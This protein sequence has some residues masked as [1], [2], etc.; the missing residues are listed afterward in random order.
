MEQL[1]Q[2]NFFDDEDVVQESVKASGEFFDDADVVD[3]PAP[4][5]AP[6]KPKP[7]IFGKIYQA[8]AD[9]FSMEKN[10]NQILGDMMKNVV[11]DVA[12][13][14]EARDFDPRPMAAG[15]TR[16]LSAGFSD[17]IAGKIAVE[18]D[19]RTPD[20]I[21]QL[22]SGV[23][24]NTD[25]SFDES[26]VD[27]IY[28]SARDTERN[29]VAQ[30]EKENPSSVMAGDLAASLMLPYGRVV[31]GAQKLTGAASTLKALEAAR[32]AKVAKAA[33]SLP[34]AKAAIEVARKA[35]ILPNLSAN[36]LSNAGIGAVEGLG[37][38]EG[39]TNAELVDDTMTAAMIAGLI[40]IGLE[41]AGQAARFGAKNL[42]KLTPE[43]LLRLTDTAFNLG[44]QGISTKS[45]EFAEQQYQ[46]QKAL[47]EEAAGV[48]SNRSNSL[49]NDRTANQLGFEDSVERE[50]KFLNNKASD[51]EMNT[52]ANAEKERLAATDEIQ[53]LKS[54]KLK[55]TEEQKAKNIQRMNEIENETSEMLKLRKQQEAATNQTEVSELESIIQE[56]AKSVQDKVTKV[57]KDL[58]DEYENIYDAADKAGVKVNVAGSINEFIDGLR[59]TGPAD[60]SQAEIDKLVNQLATYT[61]DLSL[62][63]FREA[64]D[65]IQKIQKNPAVAQK[66]KGLAKNAY[67]GINSELGASLSNQGQDG[68]NNALKA[69]NKKWSIQANI[70]DMI[71]NEI[72]RPTGLN[73]ANDKTI[74][75][76]KNL[77]GGKAEQMSKAE[78]VQA[79][80][81]EILPPEEYDSIYGL[82]KQYGDAVNFTPKVPTPSEVLATNPEY[83]Q[84]ATQR[85]ILTPAKANQELSQ[86]DQ[87]RQLIL[88]KEELN[89]QKIRQQMLQD[90]EYRAI[91][92]QQEALKAKQFVQPELT[93]EEQT[94][95]KFGA[96]DKTRQETIMGILPKNVGRTGS[97]KTQVRLDDLFGTLEQ[98]KG[99]DFK[100]NF[101]EQVDDVNLM[102]DVSKAS[103]P[104]FNR[105]LYTEAGKMQF[106][107][108]AATGGATNVA[109]RIG[110]ASMDPKSIL[111]RYSQLT[112]KTGPMT[113][114]VIA[115]SAAVLDRNNPTTLQ[116]KSAQLRTNPDPQVQAAAA[117]LEQIA[118]EPNAVKRAA[119]TFNMQQ[120]NPTNRSVFE[121]EDVENE[122][123]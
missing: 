116:N 17:E 42:R 52:L 88:K 50:K 36:V 104:A 41:G 103:A 53:S 35:N 69:T 83:Q 47:S 3:A 114:R 21:K 14:V 58:S 25:L 43:G 60:I 118:Q 94:L 28:T 119:A 111:N 67:G 77:A 97:D 92:E 80:M 102:R 84:L 100:T 11:T 91:M 123:Q 98:Q 110:Q 106:L 75:T 64:K 37:R 54:N 39:E 89:Q 73:I 31:K 81:K 13:N 62:A 101:V 18:A 9:A 40:P 59:N 6:E 57:R 38:S 49:K 65:I 85:Q 74:R 86:S 113:P 72:D 117:Q 79:Y 115:G 34:E 121:D 26:Q 45:K 66:V 7:G 16:G 30:Y 61:N 24:P 120:Q 10:P 63:Q 23:N 19:K 48:V 93:M 44:E 71:D 78:K 4:T 27:D 82:S 90:P 109:N 12:P 15:G 122:E 46:R 20:F 76:I 1:S 56:K 5:V 68:I 87:Y 8:G 107:V 22:V 51:V 29:R 108:N 105:D 32:A 70:D 2:N 99:P 112:K 55:Q 33:G 96:D 95:K